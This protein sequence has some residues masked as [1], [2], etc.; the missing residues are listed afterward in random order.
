MGISTQAKEEKSEPGRFREYK[1]VLSK[2]VAFIGVVY[3]IYEILYVLGFLTTEK[4]FLYP[5]GFRSSILGLM[6]AYTF[7]M[8]PAT[9]NSPRDRLPWYEIP[10]ILASLVV[11]GHIFINASGLMDHPPWADPLEQV[12]G[13]ITILLLFEATRRSVGMAVAVIPLFFFLYPMISRYCPGVF[14]GKGYAFDRVV[15]TMYL[16]QDG[17]FGSL[18]HIVLVTI[19]AFILFASFLQATK[20][21]QAFTDLAFALVGWL[22][23]GPAKAAVIASCFFGTISGSAVANVAGTGCVTIP[24]MKKTGYRPYF[25][26]AVE[27]VAS[28]GGQLMPPVMGTAAFIMADFLNVSYAAICLGALLP[29][30]LYYFGLFVMV[31]LEAL[32]TGLKGIP[33]NELP[34]LKTVLRRGWLY[35]LPLLV[36]IYYL[37]VA[38]YSAESSAL[39]AVASLFVVSLFKKEARLG[40]KKVIAAFE[41][42]A[43]GMIDIIISCALI[44]I[45]MGS[46]S[47]TGLGLSL[48]SGLVTLSGGHLSV[49]LLFSAAGSYVLGM[50]LPTTPCY[51]MLAALVAPAL[52]QL[53]VTAMAAHLFVF[54]FGMASMITPPVA[55]AAIV[56]A[57]IAGASMW[58]TGYTAMRLGILIL[59]IPFM[60]AYNPVLLLDGRLPAVIQAA[61]TSLIGVICLGAAVEGYFIRRANWIQRI[62]LAVAAMALIDP[63]LLTDCIGIGLLIAVVMWQWYGKKRMNAEDV[64]G[65]AA[66]QK[67]LGE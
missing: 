6:L 33:R 42:T 37:G 65:A 13:I 32:K 61:V 25:A 63:G 58:K 30:V 10:L 7:L 16:S 36:L 53:G 49:L 28:T 31:H 15:G 23:G 47:M 54:Y 48:A 56:G 20:G 11:C 44:G 17:I 29:A 62:M 26:G 14:A 18:L 5:F 50:G 51:I 40:L 1:G 3:V 39:Y 34:S 41:A 8:F 12:F 57:G 2:L 22:R 35:F 45:I 19:F 38:G 21:G 67:V 55:P 24:L 66:Q 46:L 27:A 59:I 43:R 64:K 4:I 9:K 52:T 60:F